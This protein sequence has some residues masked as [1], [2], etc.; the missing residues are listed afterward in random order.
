MV[1]LYDGV[2]D[3][4]AMRRPDEGKSDYSTF[5]NVLNIQLPDEWERVFLRHSYF[6]RLLYAMT[7]H[8]VAEL[9]RWPC[10]AVRKVPTNRRPE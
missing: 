1:I 8:L 2:N 9:I 3:T 6:C 10:K 7:H 4:F 5:R